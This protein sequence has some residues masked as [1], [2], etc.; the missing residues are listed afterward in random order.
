M[1]DILDITPPPPPEP[2]S[3][4]AA[5]DLH[6]DAV[7]MAL[8]DKRFNA[9]MTLGF[10]VLT[11]VAAWF[12]YVRPSRLIGVPGSYFTFKFGFFTLLSLLAAVSALRAHRQMR[13]IETDAADPA[14]APLPERSW[15]ARR[16]RP[17]I[18]LLL[19]I[20]LAHQWYLTR[21]GVTGPIV[22]HNATITTNTG[23]LQEHMTVAVVDGRIAF[24]GATGDA[25]PPSLSGARRIDAL[26]SMVSAATFDHAVPA[27][28]E[29]LRHIWAGQIYEGAPGDLVITPPVPPG[30]RRGGPGPSS[31][32][33]LGAVV[34]GRY[35]SASQFQKK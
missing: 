2:P 29:G 35:Y 1:P 17:L 34:N 27:P 28:L 30:R 24:V 19:L 9:L 12:D 16:A 13:A 10:A 31:R 25:E 21:A 6:H 14:A 33:I 23:S 22:F 20:A 11:L 8:H 15:I 18:L 5:R 32:E 7:Q 4:S 26:M 3:S